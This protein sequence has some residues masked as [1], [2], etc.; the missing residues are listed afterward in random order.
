MTEEKKDKLMRLLESASDEVVDSVIRLLKSVTKTASPE[1][2]QPI[3]EVCVCLDNP[4]AND[5]CAQDVLSNWG[6]PERIDCGWSIIVTLNAGETLA[7]FK[8]T[9]E[10][11]LECMGVPAEVMITEVG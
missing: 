3:C 10:E 4:T 1:K 7:G 11:E 8:R 2:A 5:G 6:E 9:V